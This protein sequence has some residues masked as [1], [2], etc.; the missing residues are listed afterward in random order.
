MLFFF[1]ASPWQ[2]AREPTGVSVFPLFQ[3]RAFWEWCPF[4]CFLIHLGFSQHCIS[5]DINIY[6][7]V[8]TVMS[9]QHLL[10]HLYK[11]CCMYM[12]LTW[13]RLGSGGPCLYIFFFFFHPTRPKYREIKMKK[14]ILFVRSALSLTTLILG[15]WEQSFYY[16]MSK[17]FRTRL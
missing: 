11:H 1:L 14:K 4:P 12:L 13:L 8:P 5:F 16:K 10:C 3:C 9:S 2:R 15:R 7:L 17:Q 6:L